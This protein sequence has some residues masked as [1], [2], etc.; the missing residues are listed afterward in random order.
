MQSSIR[1]GDQRNLAPKA[2]YMM[3]MKSSVPVRVVVVATMILTI[4][5]VIVIT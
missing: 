3:T 1:A 2:L 4:V 5:V